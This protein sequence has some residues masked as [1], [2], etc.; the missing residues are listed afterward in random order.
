MLFFLIFRK[1]RNI[2]AFRS[3]YFSLFFFQE[4]LY[5]AITKFNRLYSILNNVDF[6]LSNFSLNMLSGY[7]TQRNLQYREATRA[8]LAS[9][10]VDMFGVLFRPVSVFVTSPSS[11]LR[12]PVA[13]GGRLICH[14]SCLI[15][16]SPTSPR[17]K[18]PCR[19]R[20]LRLL[21]PF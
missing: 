8:F 17:S 4:F 13:P 18:R 15:C 6:I 19:H 11:L 20:P 12:L 14:R 7:K 9:L 1:F 3:V 16:A 10:P 5:V 21:L 2:T